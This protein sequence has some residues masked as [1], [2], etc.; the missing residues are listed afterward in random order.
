M[1]MLV[2]VVALLAGSSAQFTLQGA[3][4]F[5]QYALKVQQGAANG[6]ISTLQFYNALMYPNETQIWLPQNTVPS[7]FP[8]Q[9]YSGASLLP[10]VAG[11]LAGIPQVRNCVSIVDSIS[12]VTFQ[13]PWDMSFVQF[14]S[15]VTS[16]DTAWITGA[17]RWILNGTE[18]RTL[19]VDAVQGRSYLIKYYAGIGYRFRTIQVLPLQCTTAD[20]NRPAVQQASS[21]LSAAPTTTLSAAAALAASSTQQFNFQEAQDCK[22]NAFLLAPF[23]RSLH[24]QGFS[25]R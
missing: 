14:A 8:A 20:C 1:L 4:D 16:P 7:P 17:E 10:G 25:M 15:T 2:V 19:P 18:Q 22:Q 21:A 11:F 6:T 24:M 12:V 5:V 9:M 13:A 3:Q 23:V